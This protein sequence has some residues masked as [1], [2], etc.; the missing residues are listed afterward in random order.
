MTGASSG[1]GRGLAIELA[2]RGEPVALL[3]RRLDLLHEVA[4]SINAGTGRA[5]VRSC[6]VTD[7]AQVMAAFEEVER[8]AGP[9]ERVIANAGG[10]YRVPG[11]SLRAGDVE[12]MIAVNLVGA[13]RCIE[14]ALPGMLERGRGHLV[15]M[16]S[17][18]GTIGMPGSAA[19]SAAKAAVLRLGESLRVDLR[20]KG[21]EVTVLLPGFVRTRD[22]RKRRPFE[23]PLERAAA[24]MADAILDRRPTCRFPATVVVLIAIAGLLPARLRDALMRRIGARSRPD[25]KAAREIPRGTRP[26]NQR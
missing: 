20:P 22:R 7:P 26:E 19:Y 24:R 25:T 3:A 23:V 21:I 14:A 18:A 8:S 2:R 4:A 12:A 10:G 17:L 16:S 9:I 15:L 5:I 13:V 1:I 6:D 11:E